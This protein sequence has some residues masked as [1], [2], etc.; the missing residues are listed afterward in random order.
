MSE[1]RFL[2]FSDLE[3]RHDLIGLLVDAD[4][5]KYDFL[6]YKGDTPDPEVYKN[7]R[8]SRSLAG[9]PWEERTS[10]SIMEESDSIHSPAE[11]AAI[12]KATTR[13]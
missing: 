11:P 7:I 3:G 4:L 8:K 1:L 13:S 5:S 9:R 6:L 2:A 10:T 12:W